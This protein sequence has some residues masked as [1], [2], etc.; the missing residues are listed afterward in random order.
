[1]S[2][3]IY[4]TNRVPWDLV[5]LFILIHTGLKYTAMN[6]NIYITCSTILNQLVLVGFGFLVWLL[7]HYM[8]PVGPMLFPSVFPGFCPLPVPRCF[9]VSSSTLPLAG[10]LETRTINQ[11]SWCARAFR[12]NICRDRHISN[13]SVV[14]KSTKVYLSQQLRQCQ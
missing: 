2:C 10:D 14:A 3:P 5:A 6:I 9:M 8:Q 13:H 4:D 11:S 1:M 7:K 12:T